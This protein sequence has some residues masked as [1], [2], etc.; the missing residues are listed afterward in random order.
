MTY[1]EKLIKSKSILTQKM[2]V[3]DAKINK[4]KLEA[5]L[6]TNTQAAYWAD[7]NKRLKALYARMD[8]VFI[9]YAGYAIPVAY[10]G[11]VL[12]QI[13]AVRGLKTIQKAIKDIE[14]NLNSNFHRNT[15]S[16][17]VDDTIAVFTTSSAEGRKMISSLLR[18]TQQQVLTERKIN[19]LVAEGLG[20]EGTIRGVRNRLLRELQKQLGEDF[21]IKAGSKRFTGKYYSE[22]VAR[23][24]TR[25]AQTAGV[26]NTAAEYG[27]DLVEVSSHNTTTAI[28]IPFEGKI[29]S[30]SG[31]GPDFPALFDTP[32]FHPNCLHNITI[33]FR[34]VLERRGI[35][36]YIDFANGD[37]EIHPTRASH[38][39]VSQ[40]NT[41]A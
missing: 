4:I 27:T 40:R 14:I 19:Q 28:C 25:D 39:P 10:R 6:A 36:K 7:L 12:E 32:P 2:A 5:S 21:T 33:I 30:I 31:R 16:A 18:Q 26:L 41:A 35:Q 38:I 9:Q 17:L 24:K 15:I 20:E 22:L 29:F 3:I 13:K 34:E 11:E 1:R 37:T 23:T 8:D